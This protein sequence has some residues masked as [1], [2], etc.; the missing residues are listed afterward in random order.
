MKIGSIRECHFCGKRNYVKTGI[1]DCPNCAEKFA[2]YPVNKAPNGWVKLENH[3]ISRRSVETMLRNGDI[4]M[5]D[6]R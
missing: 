6:L 1:E 5:E 3:E 4:T 2:D